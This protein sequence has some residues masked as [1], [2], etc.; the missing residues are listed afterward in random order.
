MILPRALVLASLVSSL[1]AC[2][3]AQEEIV[4]PEV[5]PPSES[6]AEAS[7]AD[8]PATTEAPAAAEEYLADPAASPP[9]E[10]PKATLQ[11][12]E[13]VLADNGSAEG[14]AK[15]TGITP[16]NAALRGRPIGGNPAD[17]GG[18]QAGDPCN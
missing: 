11:D 12:M 4:A 7:K 13:L 16:V 5:S 8:P 3:P 15:N 17:G 10:K 1:F 9:P 6:P 2:G 18:K 14:R